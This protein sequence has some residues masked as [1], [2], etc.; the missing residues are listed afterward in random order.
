MN[1]EKWPSTSSRQPTRTSPAQETQAQ[2]EQEQQESSKWRERKAP[3]AQAKS[4]V[5]KQGSTMAIPTRR[6][7][8]SKQEQQESEEGPE[9]QESWRTKGFTWQASPNVLKGIK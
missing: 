3:I 7:S 9:G 1:Q 4:V 2:E 8:T 6:A 5:A